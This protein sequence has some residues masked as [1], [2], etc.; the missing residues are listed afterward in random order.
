MR[1]LIQL[2]FQYL[3]NNRFQDNQISLLHCNHLMINVP[4]SFLQLFILKV[5]CNLQGLDRVLHPLT[6][7]FQPFF[8]FPKH[9]DLRQVAFIFLLNNEMLPQ[10]LKILASCTN[11]TVNQVL[12][13]F[14]DALMQG[15]WP[16]QFSRI[17][18]VQ[19]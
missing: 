14:A 6:F 9:Q 4:L 10:K 1:K 16:Q 2:L 15:N 3:T 12:Q 7:L 18:L 19:L 17:F 8:F 13:Q 5:F 11:R